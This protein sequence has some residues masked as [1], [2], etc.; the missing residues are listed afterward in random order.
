MSGLCLLIVLPLSNLF[1]ADYS[2]NT[3]RKD[4]FNF[5]HQHGYLYSSF[6]PAYIPDGK[7]FRFQTGAMSYHTSAM[8]RVLHPKWRSFTRVIVPVILDFSLAGIVQL[9][10]QSDAIA[11]FPVQDQHSI[12][13]NSPR[14]SAR[15][16]LV[17]EKKYSPALAFTIGVKFS[18]AKPWN[19]WNKIHN[20]NDSNGLAGV[21]TGVADYLLLLHASKEFGLQ[22]FVHFNAG[23]APLGDPTAYERGSSQADQIPLRLGYEIVRQRWRLQIETAGMLG[24]LQT[25]NLDSY[26]VA[27]LQPAMR[28]HKKSHSQ[29]LA[30][31]LEKGLT[32]T[33]DSYVAGLLYRVTW[34][35]HD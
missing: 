5:G 7:H 6:E 15:I 18:S 29:E 9:K 16:K 23:L 20:Y 26:L 2:N 30:I 13:G 10:L 32:W 27:R 12:G 17:G 14:F 4:N 11:H 1:A 28:W 22:Q 25:T 31:N 34:D 35:L 3:I 33:T 21:G 24:A 8:P 19:I